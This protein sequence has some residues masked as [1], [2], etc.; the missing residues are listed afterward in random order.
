[1]ASIEHRPVRDEEVASLIE[2]WKA[3]DLVRPWNDPEKDIAF[4]RSGPASD[5][6]VAVDGD[7]I[8]AS[9]KADLA[10]YKAPKTVVF[11]DHVPRAP[12]GKA[13]YAA[14]RALAAVAR[15]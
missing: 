8:I 2:L 14:A 11:V 5:V 9:V 12:N 13:D 7:T 6:L 4:A 15:A 1:M 3:C 10:G